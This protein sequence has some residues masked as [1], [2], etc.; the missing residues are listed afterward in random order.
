MNTLTTAH[1]KLFLGLFMTLTFFT[2]AADDITKSPND[3]RQFAHTTL[4]N[5]LKLLVISDPEVQ[6]AAAA[7]DVYVG[8]SAEPDS[9]PGL[10]HFLEHMLFLG[11]D[12]YPDPDAYI[13][14]ISDHGGNHNAFT[15]FDHTNYFFDIDPAYLHEGLQRFSRFFVAPTLAEKYVER[16]RN[17]VDS[18]YHSKLRED[19][20]R[21]M[22]T[23]KQ[24]VNPKHP[25]SRFSIGNN[26]TLPNDSVRSALLEFYQRYY[27][28]DRMSAIIIGRESNAT[29]LQWGR[30]LFADVPKRQ[31]SDLTIAEKLFDGVKL[32][33]EVRNPSVKNEK[34]LSLFFNFPYY[35]SN[36]YNKSLGYISHVIGYEGEGSLLAALKARGYANELYSGAGYRIGQE[37]SFEIGVQLTD[38]GY[39]HSHAV[40]AMI[41]AYIELLKQDTHGASRYQEI[42]ATAATAFRYKEKQHSIYEASALATRLN[43]FPAKDVLALNAI[44]SGYN[45]N[46][47]DAYLHS[48]TAANCVVQLTAPDAL[49]GVKSPSKTRYFNVPYK[50]TSVDSPMLT[51]LATDE[52]KAAVAS[53]H[54][55]KPNRFIADDYALQKTS[56]DEKHSILPN[57]VELFYKHDVSFAVPRSSIQL[58]LQPTMPLSVADKNAMRLLADAIDEQLTATL[59][60]ADIAGVNVDIG[61]GEKSITISLN[62]YQQ[63]M[64]LLLETILTALKQHKIAKAIFSQVKTAYRQE[65]QNTTNKMPYQQTFAYLNKALLHDAS[66]PSQ[67]LAALDA[68]EAKDVEKFAEKMLGD[69]AVRLLVYGNNT[70][71]DAE[72][73]GKQLS[74]FLPTSD[75]DNSWQNHRVVTLEKDIVT[76]F[77][78]DHNDSAITYYIQAGKGYQARAQIGLLAKMLEPQFFTKLRTEM[79]LGYVVF[80]YPRPVLEQAGIAFT[81]QSPVAD[82]DSLQQHIIAFNKQF[83]QQLSDLKSGDFTA[84][85]DIL[86]AELL[87]Q[88]ENLITAAGRYWNDI[89]TTGKTASSR[90]AVAAA[91]AKITQQDF[92]KAV[93]EILEKGYS[94]SIK[95]SPKSD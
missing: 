81:I 72:S 7:V 30:E 63:K 70:Y 91:I 67:R 1:I 60:D 62:G 68:L 45:K 17:A 20:W 56:I 34:N 19:A 14:Y 3:K 77:D 27:S 33:L 69:L 4:A 80:A 36:E 12:R 61:A 35:P 95:A 84:V 29:L 10:A 2:Q 53:M 21:N 76:T 16:E 40:I 8:S 44:F 11:T 18:E 39:S 54:L 48:M 64:P 71:A 15:A 57:G 13:N 28:A 22:D 78:V 47:I 90:Q 52:D 38:K 26:E 32:P 85:K 46:Q 93:P 86:E 55:P 58:A 6:R 23:M 37:S 43:R 9:F 66:L 82:A 92:G 75:F 5:G 94:V 87:Q 65:L 42:A 24:A 49:A 25:Y 88:P 41:F 51:K 59:Y 79:Q 74:Q 83:S 31:P 50:I 89:I 73:L